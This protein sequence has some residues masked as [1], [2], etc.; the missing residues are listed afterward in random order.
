MNH[1]VLEREALHTVRLTLNGRARSG[2]ARPRL[3]LSDFLRQDLGATGTHVGCEHGVCGACTVR[4][5]GVAARA[6]LT[7]AV[8]V[9]GRHVDTVENPVGNDAILDALKAAFKRHHALQCG[10]CTSGILMSS[11]DWLQRQRA[12]G[13][14]PDEAEVRDMLSGHL[15]RCTGYTPI[16][17]A[18]MEVSRA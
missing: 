9:D 10:F 12:S 14:Q 6:C 18:L 15:C 8:Q 7:L 1:P 5:D 3:L 13:H 4:I 11:A 17:N 16:V 2:Q